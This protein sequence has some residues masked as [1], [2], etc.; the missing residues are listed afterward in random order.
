MQAAVIK[1][2]ALDGQVCWCHMYIKMVSTEWGFMHKHTSINE[3]DKGRHREICL[4]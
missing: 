4:S 3:K 2:I 1:K